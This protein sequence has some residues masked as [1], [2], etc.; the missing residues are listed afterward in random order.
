MTPPSKAKITSPLNGRG[1]RNIIEEKIGGW[2][3]KNIVIL[4]TIMTETKHGVPSKQIKGL[5]CKGLPCL[6]FMSS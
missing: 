6:I 4:E 2:G 5:G 1:N 3:K